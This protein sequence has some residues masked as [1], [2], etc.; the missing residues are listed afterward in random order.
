MDLNIL[1][2]LAE[3]FFST[4]DG[5][6]FVSVD[7]NMFKFQDLS[8]ASDYFKRKIMTEIS[9]AEDF[10]QNNHFSFF[11]QSKE[12]IVKLLEEFKIIEESFSYS[13][14][15]CKKKKK[16][17]NQLLKEI[18]I[19][20]ASIKSEELLQGLIKVRNQLL[21]TFMQESKLTEII[22]TNEDIKKKIK[23]SVSSAEEI[24]LSRDDGSEHSIFALLK[25]KKEIGFCRQ[26]LKKG[27]MFSP[28]K[29]SF[30]KIQSALSRGKNTDNILDFDELYQRVKRLKEELE[31]F[32]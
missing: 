14:E 26:E 31:S 9:V 16:V 12:K 7:G 24:L 28:Y 5:S 22:K 1:V 17:F 27:Y 32:A 19:L 23:E 21:T 15:E 10:F 30:E 13:G 29:E 4:K 11:N 25:A 6:L 18:E 2:C 8:R 20:K 3:R